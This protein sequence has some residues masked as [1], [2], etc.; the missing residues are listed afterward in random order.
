[1]LAVWRGEALRLRKAEVEL[2]SAL[3]PDVEAIVGGKSLLLVGAVLRRAGFPSADLLV[4]CLS[5]GPHWLDAFPRPGS[6][7]RRSAPP[8]QVYVTCGPTQMLFD[9]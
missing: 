1:M 9:E 4:H 2:H 7:R 6:S 3:H 5:T 8:F